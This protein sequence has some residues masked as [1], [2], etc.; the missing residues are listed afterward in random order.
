M[1]GARP[2]PHTHTYILLKYSLRHSRKARREFQV[3]NERGKNKQGIK[4]EIFQLE[5]ICE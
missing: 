1:Y 4:V 2:P 3:M 5:S